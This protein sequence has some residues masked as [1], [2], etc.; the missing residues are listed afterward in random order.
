MNDPKQHFYQ[1][2]KRNDLLKST[3][4]V[5]IFFQM[6][7]RV[8]DTMQDIVIIFESLWTALFFSFSF[9]LCKVH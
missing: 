5:M 6:S 3:V 1:I 2:C 8:E 7:L 9:L 4:S